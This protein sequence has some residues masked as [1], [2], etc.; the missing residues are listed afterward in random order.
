[1][2]QLKSSFARLS[3]AD[4]SQ[5]E[6]L[7]QR[8][9][10]VNFELG[11]GLRVLAVDRQPPA[12]TIQVVSRRLRDLRH[13]D[14]AGGKF[15][16]ERGPVDRELYF[17]ID[18][19]SRIAATPGGRRDFG[20]LIELLRRAGGGSDLEAQPIVVDLAGWAQAL[21]KQYDTAQ[22]GQL[23]VD[24]L[25]QEPRLIGRYSAK[26]VDNRVDLAYI[27]KIAGQLRSLRLGFFYEGN[28]R[29]VEAR[30]DATLSITSSEEEDAEH[31]FDEQ[32]QLLMQHQLEPGSVENS[33]I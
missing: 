25:Y 26:S 19:Q 9:R 21:L 10:R 15:V 5:L 8:L 17:S 20:S 4:P 23:V 33:I 1:M 28:R 31:F 30:A 29:S 3:H 18:L 11:E 2:P 32:R 16:S 22:L 6:S 14:E 24:S 12:L 7:A 27:E 13:F